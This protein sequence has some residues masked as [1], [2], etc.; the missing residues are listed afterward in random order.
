MVINMTEFRKKIFYWIRDKYE[1]EAQECGFDDKNNILSFIFGDIG[2]FE[3]KI[4]VQLNFMPQYDGIEEY[5]ALQF[6]FTL[7]GDV[8]TELYDQVEYRLNQLNE[9]LM[10]GA[11]A[12]SRDL[13]QVYFRY[14]L[15]VKPGDV[16]GTEHFVEHVMEEM[17]GSATYYLA[18]LL[19]VCNEEDCME[20][21]EYKAMMQ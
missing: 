17:Y 12:L 14:V 3:G 11:F 6:F 15:P 8:E 16:A 20:L 2:D 4:L 7:V 9:G 18:Y 13:R 21:E 5:E 19:V 10:F 1:G